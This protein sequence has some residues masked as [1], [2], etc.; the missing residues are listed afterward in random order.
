MSSSY[1]FPVFG[2]V[3]GRVLIQ[4]VFDRGEAQIQIGEKDTED[5]LK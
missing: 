4:E 2:D 5:P 1:W 3:A